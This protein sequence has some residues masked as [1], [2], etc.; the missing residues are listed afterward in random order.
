MRRTGVFKMKYIKILVFILAVSLSSLFFASQFGVMTFHYAAFEF[1]IDV[2]FFHDRGQTEIQVP[3][4]GK[5]RAV[6]HKAPMKVILEFKNADLDLLKAMI[7]DSPKKED[8]IVRFE[9]TFD[10]VLKQFIARLVVLGVLGGLFAALLLRLKGFR[11]YLAAGILGG[12]L[13][14]SILTWTYSTYNPEK[15]LNPQFEGM[16]K[17]APWMVGLAEEA[18]T[19]VDILGEQ[20]EIVASNLFTFLEQVDHLKPL[21]EV[22]ADLK[23]LHVT[24]I[25]NNPAALDFVERVTSLFGVDF[26]IDTGDLTDYGTPLEALLSERIAAIKVPYVFIAGNH[27]SPAVIERM[28]ALENVIVLE[29][30]IVEVKGLKIFGVPDPSSRINEIKPPS[31]AIV[32]R[33][34]ED[35]QERLGTLDVVPDLIATHSHRMAEA[36]VGKTPIVLHGHNHKLETRIIG[37]TVLLNAGTTGAAG[38]RNLQMKKEV[39]YSV[40]LLHLKQE[41]GKFQLIA[42]DSITVSN[43]TTGFVLERRLYDSLAKELGE[44]RDGAILNEESIDGT[45]MNEESIDGPGMNEEGTSELE[46]EGE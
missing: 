14:G 41:E 33:Y 44:V 29:Q 19:K 31:Q 3:P 39:P 40:I 30:E 16:L 35:A 8:I 34:S 36:F 12:V 42:S 32:E 18:L 24:D 4:V 23:V 43:M 25:H 22:Q 26:I 9:R 21:G 1:T 15:F 10:T 5:I 20:L 17:A 13:I 2:G 38:I 45:G 37:D 6:T 46:E 27:D 28:H 7:A 11:S